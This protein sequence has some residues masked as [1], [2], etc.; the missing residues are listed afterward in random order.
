MKI[1]NLEADSVL[2]LTTFDEFAEN[3]EFGFYG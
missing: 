2:S 1:T 3:H